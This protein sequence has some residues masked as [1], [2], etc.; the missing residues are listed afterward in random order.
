MKGQLQ[1]L[2]I[3]YAWGREIATCAARLLPLEPVALPADAR[4]GHRLSPAVDGELVPELPD[5]ARQRAGDRRRV[6]ALRHAGDDARARAVVPAHHRTTPTSCSTTRRSLSDW[7]EKVLTMQQN[8]IGRSTGVAGGVPARRAGRRDARPR[9]FTTRI[10][11]IYGATFVL[12]APEHPLV[13]ALPAAARTHAAAREAVARFR[14][15]DRLARMAGEVEKEG[16]VTGRFA[17]NP[18]TGERVPI[19]VGNFVLA[20]LRHRRDHGGARA[21]PARLRVRAQVRP[22]DPRGRRARGRRDGRRRRRRSGDDDRGLRR[23]RR[24]RSTRASSPACRAKRPGRRWPIAP[25]RRASAS[26]R[27]STGSRTGASRGS[28]TGARRSR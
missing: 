2:G 4:A 8:W 13:D 21:R 1:R 12:L 6:L 3:S 18:F 26:G 14:A 27:R 22:A 10:D 23:L 24:G 25:R 17:I 16:V 20:G 28:A 5:R 7:P 11:T 9:I 15:Q 19:W